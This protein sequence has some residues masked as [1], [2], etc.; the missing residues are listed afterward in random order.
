MQFGLKC[1]IEKLTLIFL[2][3]FLK[4]WMHILIIN[5]F[6]DVKII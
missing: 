2:K 6:F 3:I 1:L 5:L 4:P